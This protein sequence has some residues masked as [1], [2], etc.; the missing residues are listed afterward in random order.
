MGRVTRHIVLFLASCLTG[1]AFYWILDTDSMIWW[2]SMA[3]AYASLVLLAWTLMI[4]PWNKLRGC[5][6]PVSGYLRR[7]IGIWAGV[8][9]IVHVIAGLQVHFVGKMWLYFLPP[10]D[11]PYRFPLRIDLAG[12]SHWVG[13]FATFILL[14][15][16]YL[17]NDAS[18]RR[19]GTKRWKSLQRWNYAGAI[20]VVAHGF[21]YQFLE[22]RTLGFIVAYSAIV[23]LVVAVQ[24]AGCRAVKNSAR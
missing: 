4:G 20:L 8:L 19:Y 14:L 15:L 9:G 23:L 13:L 12:L 16:L 22:K 10:P 24:Y 11:A 17:S 6:N 7:D 2:F 21:A 1:V 18:L 3:T 5:P